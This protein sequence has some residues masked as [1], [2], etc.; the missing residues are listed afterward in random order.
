LSA[1][2]RQLKLTADDGERYNT[3]CLNEDGVKELILVLPVKRQKPIL[4]WIKGMSD[5]IDEQSKRKAYR[6]L[7]LL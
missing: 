6:L 7:L 5:P 4:A 3:D 1:N 2:C